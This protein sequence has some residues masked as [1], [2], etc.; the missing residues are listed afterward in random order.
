M[1]VAIIRR[2]QGGMLLL[3]LSLPGCAG[4]K[5]TQANFDRI[6]IGMKLSEVEAILGKP[7]SSY[8]GVVS[9]NTNHARTVIS[10]TLD[11]RGCVTEKNAD[12]L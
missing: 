4:E 10:I 7:A 11:D 9:W 3:A 8:Q 12:H 5:V 6:E 2:W 1:V